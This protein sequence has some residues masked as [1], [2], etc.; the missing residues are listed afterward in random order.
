MGAAVLARSSTT[1]ARNRVVLRYRVVSGR[2][3]PLLRVGQLG[4]LPRPLAAHLPLQTVPMLSQGRQANEKGETQ[5]L[6]EKPIVL[7]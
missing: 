3:Q 7:C 6:Q 1:F 5:R 2:E 4:K